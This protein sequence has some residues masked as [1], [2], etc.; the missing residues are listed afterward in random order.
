MCA[1]IEK[2]LITVI[3]CCYNS[4]KTISVSIESMLRQSYDNF[5]YIIVDG[6]SSDN[7]LEVIEKYRDKFNGRLTVISEKDSG[8]YDAIN[9][10]IRNANGVIIGILNSDDYYASHAL[11]SVAE[12]FRKENYPLL[13]LGGDMMRVSEFGKNIVRYSFRDEQVERKQCFGHPSMFAAKAVYDRIGLYDTGYRWAADG[14]W[15][16]RAMEDNEVRYVLTHEVYNHMREG[17]A[18]D[19]RKNRWQWFRER[20]R[21]QIAH[22]RGSRFKIYFSEFKKVI[23]T[24]VKAILPEKIKNRI[25]VNKYTE[26]RK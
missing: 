20:S 16:Y 11:E 14:D 19:N 12:W 3:T 2:P 26:R 5:E 10:G 13:V 18:T 15:Q 1:E 25:Y 24:D 7:T 17:G 21:M 4:A 6:R 23:A 8:M 22:K 9:K